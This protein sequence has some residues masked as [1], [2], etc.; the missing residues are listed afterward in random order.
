MPVLQAVRRGF[1]FLMYAASLVFAAGFFFNWWLNAKQD[2]QDVIT[3]LSIRN[4]LL[5]V[6][7]FFWL[8]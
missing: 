6:F 8:R 7:R 3:S 4:L 1:V 5:N 2:Q